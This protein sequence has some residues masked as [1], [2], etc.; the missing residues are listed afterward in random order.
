MYT[1]WTI[2]WPILEHY[3][4]KLKNLK[5]ILKSLFIQTDNE[6]SLQN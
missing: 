6:T 4:I 5:K 2:I 3:F 1:V